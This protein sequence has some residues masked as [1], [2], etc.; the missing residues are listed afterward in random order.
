MVFLDGVMLLG[1]IVDL[2]LGEKS[3]L[4]IR[5]RLRIVYGESSHLPPRL[6]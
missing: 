2:Y 4:T 6:D 5:G 1:N 3:T